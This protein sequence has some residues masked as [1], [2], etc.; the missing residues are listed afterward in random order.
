MTRHSVKNVNKELRAAFALEGCPVIVL[1]CFGESF[2]K[3]TVPI[4]SCDCLIHFNS[5]QPG[6]AYGDMGI[7]RNHGQGVIINNPP[8]DS[9]P[10]FT[11]E[12][13]VPETV[14][15]VFAECFTTILADIALH[16]RRS[17]SM[18]FVMGAFT[19]GTA[20][21]F[22]FACLGLYPWRVRTF[23]CFQLRL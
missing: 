1:V 7:C 10:L 4:H 22:G 9:F 21:E 5:A 19:V 11:G 2:E 15:M 3:V 23:F 8:Y 12:M 20:G 17:A 6:G 18:F 13:G 14:S 16:A